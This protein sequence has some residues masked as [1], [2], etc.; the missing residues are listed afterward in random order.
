MSHDRFEELERRIADMETLM[1]GNLKDGVEGAGG[2]IGMLKNISE[3]LYGNR[4]SGKRGIVDVV[5]RIEKVIWAGI[6][7][8]IA[9]KVFWEVFSHFHK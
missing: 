6:G 4:D 8:G 9:Y 3:T 1:Q 2:V 7:I 5:F